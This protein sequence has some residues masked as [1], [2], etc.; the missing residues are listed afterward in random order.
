MNKQEFKMLQ[1]IA[2]RNAM[3]SY[4]AKSKTASLPE[5]GIFWIDLT[6]AMFAESVPLN[7]AEVY[8][9]FKIF[10]GNH[11]D[12]WSKAVRANPKWKGLEYEE[13]PRGRV[14]WHNMK[15]P[16]FIIYMPKEIVK[17]REKV[18]IR[19]NLSAGRVRVDTTDEHYRMSSRKE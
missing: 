1:E 8:D 13:V 12:L 6:G 18:I 9:E 7:E 19:F 17:Y 14:T 5:V 4:R 10:G 16:E 15:N 2:L 3:A 11:Y